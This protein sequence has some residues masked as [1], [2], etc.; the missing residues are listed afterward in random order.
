LDPIRK[1]VEREG[2]AP[3][4][5]PI[6]PVARR[7]DLENVRLFGSYARGEAMPNSDIDLLVNTGTIYSLFKV[8][9]LY[10]DWKEA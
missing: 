1:A 4:K 3:Y 10:A 2:A 6:E 7:Y 5:S 9:G 8:S